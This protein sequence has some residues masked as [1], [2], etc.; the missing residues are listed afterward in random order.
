MVRGFDYLFVILVLQ[1]DVHKYL[2]DVPFR[3]SV[4]LGASSVLAVQGGLWRA[5]LR[6]HKQTGV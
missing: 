6:A 2:G 5:S 1:N 3:R 4:G